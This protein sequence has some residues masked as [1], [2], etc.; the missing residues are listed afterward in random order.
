MG[1]KGEQLTPM[2]ELAELGVRLFTDD[3]R[4]VQDA[5]LMRRALEYARG[6]GGTLAQHCDD[7]ALSSGGHMHEGVV[8]ARLGLPGAAD[9]PAALPRVASYA[10][11]S[12][13]I[14]L[15]SRCGAGRLARR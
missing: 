5:R 14:N 10:P 9:F 2:P 3:G 8:S 11:E 1:R 15:R 6:L 12:Q 13:P 7:E 4:G